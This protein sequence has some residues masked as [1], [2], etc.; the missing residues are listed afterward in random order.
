[1]NVI[2]DRRVAQCAGQ[3]ITRRP[4]LTAF[5]DTAVVFGILG[6]LYVAVIAVL[7]P[8][9]LSFPIV[10]GIPIRRDTFGTFCFGV[11]AVAYFVRAIRQQSGASDDAIYRRTVSRAL[12][13]TTFVYST[14][15]V[16]YLL[17]NSITHPETMTL[18][19]SHFLGWPTEG[20]VLVFALF[21]SVLS[22]FFLQ[23][24]KYCTKTPRRS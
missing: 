24:S 6:W 12:S 8:D 13:S 14:T 7:Y 16:I 17:A 19:F 10:V 11:S 5:I 3:P 4:M 21:C 9:E 2:T 20:A 18:P 22:F 15:V 23:L 1:M